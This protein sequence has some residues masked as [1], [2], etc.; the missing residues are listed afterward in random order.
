MLIC[1]LANFADLRYQA[2]QKQKCSQEWLM[3]KAVVEKKREQ[4][5]ILEG[6]L[7]TTVNQEVK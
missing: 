2:I 3:A 5:H 6:R 7:E 1:R 4:M